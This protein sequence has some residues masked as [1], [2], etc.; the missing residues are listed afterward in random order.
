MRTLLTGL[1]LICMAS[2]PVAQVKQTAIP[3][4]D[5]LVKSDGG[6]SQKYSDINAESNVTLRTLADS[7]QANGQWKAAAYYWMRLVS[8][9]GKAD[10][11]ISLGIAQLHMG[12]DAE[13]IVSFQ[14]AIVTNPASFDAWAN[15]GVAHSRVQQYDQAVVSLQKALTLNPGEFQTRLTLAK[16]L[17]SVFRFKEALAI[18]LDCEQRAPKDPEVLGLVGQIQ[19]F[20]GQP[21]E[22]LSAFERLAL[23]RTL[24]ATEEADAGRTLMLLDRPSEARTH[25][26]RALSLDSA[27]TGIHFDLARC[28][29]RMH[30][31]DIEEQ[32]DSLAKAELRCTN[33]Q[34]EALA[35]VCD[36]DQF[37]S[38][39]DRIAASMR[40]HQALPL[41]CGSPKLIYEVARG[42]V[43]LGEFGAA[44]QL[45]ES[46]HKENITSAN[47][48][49]LQALLV[50]S[51]GKFEAAEADLREALNLEPSSILALTN[52]GALLGKQGRLS[53]AEDYLESATEID[54]QAQDTLV[55]LALIKAA[56][57][58]IEEANALLRRALKSPGNHSRA[59][60]AL[61]ALCATEVA[62][63]SQK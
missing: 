52:M 46:A 54:P 10:D 47:I 19:L 48:L 63:C 12:K 43:N 24:T 55:D 2:E 39:G 13:A 33:Q 26:L 14:A 4:L 18:A 1:A 25:F 21:G 17:T 62:T 38:N 41:V 35:L 27:L 28:A 3:P 51:N 8:L 5:Q 61:N 44:A 6:L 45:L 49:T 40:Y 32:E 23:Q 60:T 53:E 29:R 7:S 22:A 50:E 36:A 56:R 59:V 11:R 15:L 9:Y 34:A 57:N 31:R 42:L 30:D 58:H 37:E 16:A 20:S